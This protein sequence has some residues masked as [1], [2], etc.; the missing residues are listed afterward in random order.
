MNDTSQYL[1]ALDDCNSVFDADRK[2]LRAVSKRLSKTLSDHIEALKKEDFI[3]SGNTDIAQAT[4]D[5]VDFIRRWHVL[6]DPPSM[7]ALCACAAEHFGI[8][9]KENLMALMMA[10][11]LGELENT[12]AYHNNNHFRKVLLQIIRLIEVHNR[13]YGGT[14]K[15][16]DE[17]QVSI[18]LVA[19]CIH[20]YGHDGKG[21]TI[22]GVFHQSRLELLA[23]EETKPFLNAVGFTHDEIIKALLV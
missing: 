13:V 20:D 9:S 11:V 15:A 1:K 8:K 21:N 5:C 22:K 7:A 16:F 12:Q 23:F 14:R 2:D 3:F 17:D 6:G 10:S 18:L 4:Q 19:A